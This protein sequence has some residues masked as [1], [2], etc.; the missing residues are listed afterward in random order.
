VVLNNGAEWARS[1]VAD[2]V[3]FDGVSSEIIMDNDEA[4]YVDNWSSYS[5][6]QAYGSSAKRRATPGRRDRNRFLY[7]QTGGS[8]GRGTDD[9]DMY[10]AH[11]NFVSDAWDF[12]NDPLDPYSLDPAD[13][14]G[15]L[16]LA[17]GEA[18]GAHSSYSGRCASYTEPVPATTP[19][20]DPY[21]EPPATAP[22]AVSA[23][24]EPF[25]G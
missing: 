18:G 16:N 9:I 12:S 7:G 1:V 10:T 5:N 8:G 24:P 22:P 6:A 17:N 25:A 20:S 2:A 11:W 3:R 15:L 23:V 14:T 13:A 19:A 4:T 21:V